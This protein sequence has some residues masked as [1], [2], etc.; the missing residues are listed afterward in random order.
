MQDINMERYV[1][2][3]FR[4]DEELEY[5]NLD[6]NPGQAAQNGFD[7]ISYAIGDFEAEN[8]YMT[9]ITQEKRSQVLTRIFGPENPNVNKGAILLLDRSCVYFE[10]SF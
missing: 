9:K 6:D 7:D 3:I 8:C 2:H 4:D 10:Q 1:V 5:I